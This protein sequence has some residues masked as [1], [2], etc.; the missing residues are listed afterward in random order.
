LASYRFNRVYNLIIGSKG[1]P[2]AI[3]IEGLRVTFDIDKTLTPWPNRSIIK[4][5]NLARS[6]R[7]EFELPDTYVAFYAGYV[8]ENGPVLIYSGNVSYAY[9][10]IAS[11]QGEVIT[12]LEL[13]DGHV[14]L[15]DGIVTVSYGPNASAKKILAV[16]AQQMGLALYMSTTLT[17]KIWNNGFSSHGSGR[18]A[19]ERITAAAGW[20]WSIQN[21]V[22]QI[23]ARGQTTA[24]QIVVLNSGSG[25]VGYPRRERK[26]PPRA[27][28]KTVVHHKPLSPYR[29]I[30][31]WRVKSLLL[32]GL[33]PGDPVQM[34]SQTIA[35]IFRVERLLHRGDSDGGEWV[36]EIYI[37]KEAQAQNG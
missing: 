34:D 21:S 32:P 2:A 4:I 15:R 22:L 5:Y 18:A 20:Q 1:S 8:E 10:E 27:D 25:L 17:D 11:E 35:G 9:S 29:R 26:Y 19:L 31:G 23:V 30:D 6:H 12:T 16:V 3:K 13:G 7:E 37:A 28:T 14:P 24:R 33:N 36:T